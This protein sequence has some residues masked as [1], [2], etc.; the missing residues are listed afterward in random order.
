MTP[1]AQGAGVELAYLEHGSGPAVVLVHDMAS[2][3]LDLEPLALGLAGR[4]RVIAYARRGYGGSTAP[5]PYLGTTVMEQAEDLAAL[6]R[7]IGAAP[8]V[9]V[10][11]GFGALVVLDLVLRHPG[12][13]R[14]AVLGEP[15][16][17]AFVPGAA[18]ALSDER[19]RIEAAVFADGPAAGV[20]AWLDARPARAGRERALAAHQA[21]FADYAGLAS[22]PVTRGELRSIGVPVA[23]VT[24]PQTQPDLLA[25]AEA[26]AQLIPGAQRLTDGDLGAA[27]SALLVD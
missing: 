25:A 20:G 4:A 13:V 22:R 5:E 2:D 23:V 19:V 27:A 24:G 10:G 14:A 9:A 21:F 8:A 1:S 11:A 18:R 7:A 16:L 3:H 17:L 15:P 26:V 12:L 6:L